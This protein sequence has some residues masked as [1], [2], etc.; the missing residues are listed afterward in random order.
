MRLL[1]QYLVS[2]SRELQRMGRLMTNDVGDDKRIRVGGGVGRASSAVPTAPLTR[3]LQAESAQ[4][5]GEELAAALRPEARV[6]LLD[7]AVDGVRAQRQIEGD[8]LLARA[9]AQQVEHAGEPR[10][11]HQRR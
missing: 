8:L 2:F 6:Q 1:A 7:V 11:Q 4:R 9:A 10:R 5:F 3:P